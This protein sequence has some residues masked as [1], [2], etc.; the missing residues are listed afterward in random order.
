MELIELKAKLVLEKIKIE[1]RMNE[2]DKSSEEYP[3]LAV[4]YT[5]VTGVLAG[6]ENANC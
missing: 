5:F 1:K 3:K 4:K 2:V 6:L